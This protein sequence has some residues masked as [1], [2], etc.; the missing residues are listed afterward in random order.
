MA[1]EI[2]LIK[3]DIGAI[4]KFP[5]AELTEPATIQR[6]RL[7]R[8]SGARTGRRVASLPP[9]IHHHPWLFLRGLI[10]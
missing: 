2:E 9:V 8:R 3:P 7:R 1:V 5:R 6:C 10:A 4:V